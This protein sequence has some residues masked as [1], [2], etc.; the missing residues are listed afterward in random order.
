MNEILWFLMC[1][2]IFILI[3]LAYK[4]FG[5][6][7]LY[8]WVG[9]SVIL[10]NVQVA[11]IISFFGLVTA[12]GNVI[13][14]SSFLATDILAEKYGKKEA[15]KAVFI[16]FFMLVST[17]I[18]MKLTLLFIPHPSDTLSPALEQ[19][20]G[21]MPDATV[22]SLTAY[23][24]SQLH[25]VWAF[26]FWKTKTGGRHL[27]LRNNASTMVSQLIDN[28]VFTTLFFVIFNPSFVSSLGLSGIFEIFL[29]SY[30]MKFIVAVL[31]TPFIYLSRRIEPVYED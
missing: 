25:D 20:F 13:Y 12:M 10:A 27:W 15:R 5:K 14:G 31:D 18:I 23:L 2:T 28:A 11:K 30:L 1:F 4:F 29:T 3:T 22:A 21:F 16:G 24:I 17:A 7:G 26:H 9:I 19:I 8:A 6:S